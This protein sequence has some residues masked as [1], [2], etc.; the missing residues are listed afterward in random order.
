VS[1]EKSDS[2]LSMAL[3]LVNSVISPI[4]EETSEL[5]DEIS[6]ISSERRD[7]YVRGDRSLLSSAGW[8]AE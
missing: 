7:E 8:H 3:F 1:T 4:T 5:G 2:S 6:I